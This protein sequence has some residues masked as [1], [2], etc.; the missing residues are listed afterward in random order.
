[1]TTDVGC[2]NSTIRYTLVSQDQKFICEGETLFVEV[3]KKM[4][5]G[6]VKINARLK[7]LVIF[8]LFINAVFSQ[9]VVKILDNNNTIDWAVVQDFDTFHFLDNNTIVEI[10]SVTEN[11]SNKSTSTGD[12]SA[13]ANCPSRDIKYK[14]YQLVRHGTW[15]SAWERTSGYGYCGRDSGQLNTLDF[16]VSW[17]IGYGISID[18]G[19]SIAKVVELMLGV[20]ISIEKSIS[21]TQGMS[22]S[23]QGNEPTCVWEQSELTW[24]D[25]QVQTCERFENCD[26]G[27]VSCGAWLK[28]QRTNAPI[29]NDLKAFNFGCS[30]GSGC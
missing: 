24:S 1:M 25:T 11:L 20:G 14:Q 16:S 6:G 4:E 17:T 10:V 22:C 26:G 27:Y 8:L 7:F 18:A 12:L 13:R 30:T 19:I 3:T 9:A 5:S 29:K 28:Y 21:T 23:C 15:W 2:G